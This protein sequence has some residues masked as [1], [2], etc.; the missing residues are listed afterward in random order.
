MTGSVVP[1]LIYLAG[2]QDDVS[3]DQA[4][5]WREELAAG[6][7]TGMAFFSPAHAYLNVHRESFPPVDWMNRKAISQSH[8]VIANLGGPGRGFGT[9]REIEYAVS[10]HKM[11]QVVGDLDLPLMTWDIHRAESLDAA[12]NAILEHVMEFRS[13]MDENMSRWRAMFVPPDEDDDDD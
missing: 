11:V 9:I 6:A 5:G 7:P 2:P 4:R 8:A 13:Q 1:I 10:Q 3:K 12:L